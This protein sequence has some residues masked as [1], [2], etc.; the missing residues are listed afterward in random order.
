M[1]LNN[2]ESSK[3][4]ARN[5]PAP[6]FTPPYS[7]IFV[8]VDSKDMAV[9]MSCPPLEFVSS[10]SLTTF[11]SLLWDQGGVL[12]INVAA[13]KAS[14]CSAAVDATIAVFGSEFVS[15]KT[16]DTTILAHTPCHYT[17]CSYVYEIKEKPWN[18]MF[19]IYL[20]DKDVIIVIFLRCSAIQY[21]LS[22]TQ[23]RTLH[24]GED[25]T[26]MVIVAWKGLESSTTPFHTTQDIEERLMSAG[27]EAGMTMEEAQD[28][29]GILQRLK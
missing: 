15:D 7:A 2:P 22:L 23:V 12:L 10:S 5:L 26:N 3:E 18:S 20:R 14:M 29:S 1:K 16:V 17:Y 11:H 9:G 24:V 4:V 25:E 19:V 6:P 13:R 28:L 8:D 27:I 21:S